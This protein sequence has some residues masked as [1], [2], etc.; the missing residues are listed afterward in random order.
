MD[1]Y[2]IIPRLSTDIGVVGGILAKYLGRSDVVVSNREYDS[3][4]DR[5]LINWRATARNMSGKPIVDVTRDERLLV[6]VLVVATHASMGLY[7]EGTP[8]LHKPTAVRLA[9]R[10]IA[11]AIGNQPTLWTHADEET[12]AEWAFGDAED[13]EHYAAAVRHASRTGSVDRALRKLLSQ[14]DPR[15]PPGAVV[16]VCSDVL[17]EDTILADMV[18][19]PLDMV[20]LM[21][22]DGMVETTFPD[23]SWETTLDNGRTVN[24]NYQGMQIPFSNPKTGREWYERVSDAAT[25]RRENEDRL[26]RDRVKLERFGFDLIVLKSHGQRAVRAAMNE[27]MESRKA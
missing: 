25:L 6:V 24:P 7:P 4:D 15:V 20:F 23:G 16:Y 19:Y 8:W 27:H 3:S 10:E 1:A 5:R 13:L 18:D 9:V 2:R 14:S 21:P 17:P 12:F 26:K 11:E 22:L